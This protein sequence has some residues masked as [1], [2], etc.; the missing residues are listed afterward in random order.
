MRVPELVGKLD[1]AKAGSA[2]AL[3]ELEKE[4]SAEEMALVLV[5]AK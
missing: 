4:M 2:K 1:W 5:S 3:G